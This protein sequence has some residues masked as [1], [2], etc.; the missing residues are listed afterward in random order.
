VAEPKTKKTN[1]SVAGFIAAVESD[2]R[3]KDAKTVLALMKKIT[4]EEPKM[5]GPSIIGFGSYPC[6]SGKKVID[7]PR[8]GFSP[9]KAS[10]VLYIVPEVLASD[11]LMKK[12]GKFKTGKSCLYVNRLADVD[13]RVLAELVEQSVAWMSK[14]YPA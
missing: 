11:P 7:W 6:L 3:R 2:G 10:L 12:L 5:W 14:K 8:A 4:G 1:A 13:E 9:R